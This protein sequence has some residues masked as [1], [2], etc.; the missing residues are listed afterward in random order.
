MGAQAGTNA[1]GYVSTP[2][3]DASISVCPA[4]WR[5]PTSGSGG[6]FA[7]L[8]TAINSSS[9]TSSTLLRS[10]WLGQYSGYW[11]SGAFYS[12]GSQASYWSS[13]NDS[14]YYDA[15]YLLFTSSSVNTS[16]GDYKDMGYA[17]RCIAS[18]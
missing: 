13:T 10:T 18:Q 8:N 12:L 5:L 1:C 3:A 4:N 9:T 7:A 16:Y 15:N 11:D 17:V 6:E 14:N 2:V